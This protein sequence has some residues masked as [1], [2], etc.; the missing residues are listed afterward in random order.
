LHRDATGLSAGLGEA[1]GELP[2]IGRL[3]AGDIPLVEATLTLTDWMGRLP[4][5]RNHWG[6]VHGDFELDNMAWAG[7][8]SI[9]YD[10]DEAA[11]SWFAADIACAVRDLTDCTGLTGPP[12]PARHLPSSEGMAGRRACVPRRQG[13]LFNNRYTQ[14]GRSDAAGGGR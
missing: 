4:R 6:V 10:F 11:V 8:R 9:A 12:A 7:S 13:S 1:F 3:F 2:G 14:Q 5:D